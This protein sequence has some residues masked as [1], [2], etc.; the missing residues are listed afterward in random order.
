M[1]EDYGHIVG[2]G[3]DTWL[4]VSAF[5]LFSTWIGAWAH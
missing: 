3:M 5:F 4:V 1:E 2:I